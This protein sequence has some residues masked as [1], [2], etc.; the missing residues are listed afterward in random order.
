M[1]G[2]GATRWGDT[3]RK[4]QGNSA[5]KSRPGVPRWGGKSMEDGNVRK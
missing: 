3:A 2:L 1:I 5:R 4:D